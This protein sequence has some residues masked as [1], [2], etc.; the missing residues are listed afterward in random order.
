MRAGKRAAP[1]KAMLE[2]G[3][4]A[5]LGTDNVTANNSYDMFK[6]MQVLGKLMSY[7]EGEPNPISSQK[8]VEMATIDGARALGLQDQ[9]GSLESGK[10]ADLIA[11]DLDEVGWGP[12]GAQDIYTALVYSINGL[13]VTDTMVDGRWLMRDRTLQTVDYRA[14]SRDLD[15]AYDELCRRRAM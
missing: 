5:A 11:L 10:R 12:H 13:Y 6:E 2:A 14:A 3:I 9:V 1:L 15:T 7:R 4:S 8:I